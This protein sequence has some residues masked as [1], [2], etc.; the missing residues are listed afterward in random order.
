MKQFAGHI[1]E[2]A[3][4][5]K[6]MVDELLTLSRLDDAE[7]EDMRIDMDQSVS[8]V[9]VARN[10]SVRLASAARRRGITVGLNVFEGD[11]SGDVKVVGN[12]RIIEEML[13]NLMEN[14]IRYNVDGGKV[15]VCVGRNAQGLAFVR[16]ADTGMGIPED[17]REKVFERFFCVDESRSKE[18]GG[19]GLGLAIVKH[20]AQLHGA[21]VSI[22]ENKPR[23]SVFEVLFQR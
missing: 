16:V 18:T 2:E 12:A 20:A 8:L 3:Q 11:G 6:S 5:M 21:S 17:M 10:V 15:D 4:H 22:S 7:A 13:R 14:A 23:G 19:S 9:E 1:Y